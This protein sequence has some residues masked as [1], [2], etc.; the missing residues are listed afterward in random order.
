MKSRKGG[1]YPSKGF[2]R[3]AIKSMKARKGLKSKRRIHN[4]GLSRS[5]KAGT[6]FSVGKIAR[7]IKAGK[8]SERT[9]RQAAVYVTAVVEYLVAELLELAGT[10]VEDYNKQ[11][12]KDDPEGFTPR[13]RIIPR[14][15]KLA[16]S[17]DPELNKL[18]KYTTIAS[19]GTATVTIFKN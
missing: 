12:Y 6:M 3:N 2:K 11:K 9:G 15:I 8:Y 13:E 4:D 18:T 16:L 19:G 5:R 1:K 14:D 10:K 17:N 7:Q